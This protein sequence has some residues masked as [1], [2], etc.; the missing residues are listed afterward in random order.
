MRIT[1]VDNYR[2]ILPL[3]DRT[4][5]KWEETRVWKSEANLQNPATGEL[6]ENVPTWFVSYQIRAGESP[7]PVEYPLPTGAQLE[8]AKQRSYWISLSEEL[9]DTTVT[10]LD[11]RRA[12]W[13]QGDAPME[14][15]QFMIPFRTMCFAMMLPASLIDERLNRERIIAAMMSHLLMSVASGYVGDSAL[16]AAWV[17]GIR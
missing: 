16:D 11:E 3:P 6:E 2:T 4:I 13:K 12:N 15:T 7:I 10:A 17:A 14:G 5:V 8:D 1:G 9:S